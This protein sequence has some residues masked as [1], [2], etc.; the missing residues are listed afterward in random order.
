VL[1]GVVESAGAFGP[2]DDFQSLSNDLSGFE[3]TRKQL[4]DRT[5]N[6]ATSK[7]QEIVR[8]RTELKT[9]Q[10]AIPVAPPKKIVVDDNEPVKKKPVVKK[11]PAAKK[12]ATAPG[13]APAQAAPAQPKP[14]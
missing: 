2:K 1:G 10:A 7:E 8:L 4:A 3:G 9:A 6:L 5:N 12:P 13:T 14:Q 11:K